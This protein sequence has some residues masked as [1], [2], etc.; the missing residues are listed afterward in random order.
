MNSGRLLRSLWFWVCEIP[1][2]SLRSFCRDG[3]VVFFEDE[4]PSATSTEPLKEATRGLMNTGPVSTET[5]PYD[6]FTYIVNSFE[7]VG[8]GFVRSLVS[9]FAPSVG[10]APWCFSKT[11]THVPIFPNKKVPLPRNS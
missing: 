6:L 3:A 11:Y 10:T 1:R 9:P 5:Y 8:F 2:Q 4:H 7:Y